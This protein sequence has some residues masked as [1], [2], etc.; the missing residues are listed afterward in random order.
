M[1]TFK[2]SRAFAAT[3]E[4]VFAAFAEP[5]RLARWWGPDGFRNTFD[6]FEFKPGGLWRFTMHGPDGSNYPNESTFISVEPSRSIVVS[7]LFH[8]C[9]QLSI[10]LECT[11]TGTLVTWAQTFESPEVAASIKHIVVPANEQNLSRWQAEVEAGGRGV[12]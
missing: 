12:A 9:F 3:P 4:A 2:T 8:P 5:E 10:G 7:H 1:T 11:A 6:T